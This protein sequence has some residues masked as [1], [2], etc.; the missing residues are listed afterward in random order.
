MKF[1]FLIHPISTEV[2]DLTR[3]DAET[4]V[5]KTWGTDALGLLARIHGP[6]GGSKV[7]L[8]RTRYGA[9]RR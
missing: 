1:A 6:G 4:G 3:L 8:D 2:S 7:Q 9:F 5:L